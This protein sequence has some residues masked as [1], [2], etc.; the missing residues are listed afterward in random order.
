MIGL[1][2]YTPVSVHG[3][4][5]CT[6]VDLNLDLLIRE[7]PFA[8]LSIWMNLHT[9]TNYYRYLYIGTKF[10][11]KIRIF[12][13]GTCRYWSSFGTH[14]KSINAVHYFNYVHIWLCISQQYCGNLSHKLRHIE[15]QGACLV[16]ILNPFDGCDPVFGYVRES[17][18]F[19]NMCVTGNGL[20]CEGKKPAI[21]AYDFLWWTREHIDSI[22]KSTHTF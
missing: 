2:S 18:R 8:I 22:I 16:L 1:E 20:F 7:H 11:V 15:W 19:Q 21:Y 4:C 12:H 14:T 3:T 13:K 17:S 10:S 9:S 5:I 6:G